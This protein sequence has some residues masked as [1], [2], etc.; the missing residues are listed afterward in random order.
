MHLQSLT[1]KNFRCFESIDV[2]FH[3]QLTVIVGVNGAGKTTILEGAAIALSTLFTALDGPK[4]IGIEKEQ[5]HLKAYTVGSTSDVQPQFPVEISAKAYIDGADIAWSRKLNTSKGQTTIKD[6]SVLINIAKDYQNRLRKGDT[7]LVLP[8]LAYYGPARLWGYPREKKT[9]ISG[10][11]TRTNGYIDS[12]NGTANIKLMLSWFAKMTVQKYQNQEFGLGAVPELYAVYSAMEKCYNLITDS[13][14]SKVQYNISTNE[15]DISYTDKYKQR[16]CIAI[17][18]LSDGYKSML[19]LVA[20]IAYRMAVLNPQLLG[21][22]IN[23]TDGIVLIDEVDMHLHPKCQWK[24]IAALQTIFPKVQFIAA[25]HSPILIAS[26]KNGQLIHVEKDE[27]TYKTSSYGME[28]ND[29][30]CSTQHSKDIV[31]AVKEQLDAV[32]TLIENEKFDQAKS[33]IA[34]LEQTLGDSHPE[35]NKVKTAYEFEKAV[36][37]DES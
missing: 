8:V 6:A 20:D 21:N 11:N 7:S 10:I 3:P 25:T 29:V 14:D 30:L 31:D 16:M 18:Q 22:V 1:L 33:R 35:L 34:A 26:C 13:N 17:N 15:L 19:S 5:V 23:Q 32:Y 28:V 12:L 37:G 24:I 27:I 9:D 4:G 2:A 36:A